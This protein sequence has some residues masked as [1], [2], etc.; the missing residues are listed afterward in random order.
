MKKALVLLLTLSLVLGC[1]CFSALAADGK[2][3]FQVTGVTGSEIK[4]G[5]KITV[6][7]TVPAAKSPV[8][9]G[10]IKVFFDKDVLEAKSITAAGIE[11]FTLSS[12]TEPQNA[13][14]NAWYNA[15]IANQSNVTMTKP[16]TLTAVF[17]VK[18]NAAI[19]EKTDL[20][21]L[22]TD[23]GDY[24]WANEDDE[25]VEIAGFDGTPSFSA[26]VVKSSISGQLSLTQAGCTY[27]ETLADPA[28]TKPQGTTKEIVT[29]SGTLRKGGE[30]TETATKPTEAGSYTV[31][32]VCEA[33]NATYTDSKNFTI[34]PLNITGAEVVLDGSLTYNG[35]EQTQNITSVTKGSVVVPATDYTLAG[36]AGTDAGNYTLTIT[37]K[38]ASNFTGKVTKAF[39]IAKKA[40]TPT[41]EITGT[42][43]YNG[44][45]Q[46]PT[47]TVK[48]NGVELAAAEY[49][50]AVAN[51]INAGKGVLTIKVKADSNYTFSDVVKEFDIA[52]ASA[53]T[54]GN[55]PI[56]HKYTLTGEQTK[57]IAALMTGTPGNMT[58]A[59]GAATGDTAIVSAWD[60]NASGVLSYT[61]AGGTAGQTVTLP[62]TISSVNYEDTPVNVIITLTEKEGQAELKITGNDTVVYG[63]TL[64]LGTTGGSGS[65]A[66]TYAVTNSTGEAT[67][68]AATGVLTTVKAGTVQ[69]VATKAED[70]DYAVAISAPLT[71]TIE[72]AVPTGAPSYTK[73]TQSGKTLADANLAIGTIK[74]IGGTIA[75]ELADT[76]EVKANTS[77]KWVYTPA[78]PVN[79]E[80]L[81]GSVK[82][83]ATGSS[84]GGGGSHSGGSSSS[85]SS[86]YSVTA[87]K[88][89]N[90]TISL[91]VTRAA[92]GDKVT[93]TVKPDNGYV[94]DKLSV[95]DEKGKDITVKSSGSQYTFIMIDG[96]VTVSATFKK[97]DGETDK[98]N[99][100]KSPFTD[101]KE[102]DYFYNAV[103]WAVEKDITKGTNDTTFGAGANCTRGQMMTFL[104]RAAGAPEVTATS[105]PFTDVAG[106][107]YYA[108]AV[109]WA[110]ENGITNGMTENTFAPNA[111]VTRGQTAAMLYRFAKA[112]APEAGNGFVDVAKDAYY[113]DAV[114]WAAENGITNGVSDTAFAPGND[115]LRSEIVT[116][117]YRY[118]VK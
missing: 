23:P 28:Y 105:N 21:R 40:I 13:N 1:F 18:S 29:Y 17:Q 35:A 114:Q 104:W 43:Q 47:Y 100:G 39:T 20:I 22:E 84:I 111:T 110:V 15:S 115:C 9:S 97:A 11:A 83:Y 94:L 52:K 72:K 7:I 82:L 108:K 95:Y 44:K 69:V 30:Y 67:I 71:I 19:G 81:T 102:N 75:W 88:A 56:S 61:L 8:S 99:S 14:N 113:Y 49:T 46:N 109:L 79:Y 50:A 74:P 116:F 6:A 118:F 48:D 103:M 37:A 53:Q 24:Y 117:L 101:V 90:G 64:K 12:V 63:N 5:D 93:I 26:T 59:K 76:T 58:Y 96:K 66:V 51:N 36:N 65:G 112:S 34:A 87:E 57:N 27:G 106:D 33:A 62:I 42:Y 55:L 73:I 10:Q 98:D 91:D 16:V 85:G 54:I 3:T 41:V 77:Y 92:K 68:D 107:S 78:D 60:V 25:D 2:A 80:T 4:A 38:D 70:A 45:A 86:K 31:K 89:S 32:V